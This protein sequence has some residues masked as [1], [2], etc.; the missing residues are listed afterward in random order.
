MGIGTNTLGYSYQPVE[1]K[2]KQS[3]FKSN[4]SSLNSIENFSS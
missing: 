3:L 1:N 2:I 4:M